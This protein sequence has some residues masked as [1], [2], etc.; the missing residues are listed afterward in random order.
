[1]NRREAIKRSFFVSLLAAVGEMPRLL[2]WI[3]GDPDMPDMDE[4]KYLKQMTD[5][6]GISPKYLGR[7]KENIGSVTILGTAGDM[8]VNSFSEMWKKL[9]P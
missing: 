5:I 6:T 2:D 3:W 7:D 8:K 9:K 4:R 1:M